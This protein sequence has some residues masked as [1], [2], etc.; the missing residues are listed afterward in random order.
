MTAAHGTINPVSV[1][2][3]FFLLCLYSGV[4]RGLGCVM[5]NTFMTDIDFDN[6][7]K[8]DELYKL[9]KDNNRMLHAQ[10]RGAFLRVVFKLVIFVSIVTMSLWLYVTYATPFFTPL[11]KQLQ[12]I[13]DAGARMQQQLTG[14]QQGTVNLLSHA[15]DLLKKA[16]NMVTNLPGGGSG[17]GQ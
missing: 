15:S 12:G 14:V 5:Y 6:H 7:E 9:E 16:Q 13:T 10:R 2:R 1:R 17:A 8:V 11:L 3:F 4:W